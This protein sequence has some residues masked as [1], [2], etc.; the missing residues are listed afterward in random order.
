M[1]TLDF[2]G[3][4]WEHDG[5][6]VDEV[7]SAGATDAAPDQLAEL[8]EKFLASEWGMRAPLA[9]EQEI[10]MPF[11]GRTLVCKIDAIYESEPGQFQIVDWKTGRPPENDS[12]AALRL[13]QLELYRHAFA[14]WRGIP[15]ER[16]ECVLFYVATGEV[17]RSESM[18]SVSELESRWLQAFGEAGG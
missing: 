4:P 9:L 3:Y 13:L 5:D 12:D 11:A 6:S 16:I 14:S 8:Q 7:S 2:D 18:L 10:T 17:V 15:P 1:Q